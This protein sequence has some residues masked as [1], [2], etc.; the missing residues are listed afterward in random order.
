[1]DGLQHWAKKELRR[2][3]V[4]NVD[5]AIAV[6]KPLVDFNM[7]T[8]KSKGGNVERAREI[9]KRTTRKA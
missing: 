2:H 8:A 7:E 6:A 1:M 3:Q 9:I 5:E 4:A